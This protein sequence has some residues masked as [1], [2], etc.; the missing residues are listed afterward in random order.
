MGLISNEG[1]MHAIHIFEGEAWMGYK[2]LWYFGI[3]PDS[4]G[5]ITEPPLKQGQKGFI[6][7]IFKANEVAEKNK[8]IA[9]GTAYFK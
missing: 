7:H 3:V 2:L 1:S 8:S 9:L 6:I 4:A 5:P